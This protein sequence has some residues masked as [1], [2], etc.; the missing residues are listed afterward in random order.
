MLLNFGQ[1]SI[2]LSTPK[3]MGVVN[4]TPDSF[5]DGGKIQSLSDALKISLDMERNGAAIIDIGGESTRPG[6]HEVSSEIQISRVIPLIKALRE[7]S[8]VIISIDT[9]NPEVME[10][11]SFHIRIVRN[12]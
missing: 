6:S 7:S 8:D 11:S 5:S 10:T 9:G 4:M 12:Q 2:D 1:R 3:I